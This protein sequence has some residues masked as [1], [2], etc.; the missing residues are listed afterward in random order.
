MSKLLDFE[1]LCILIF[2]VFPR[3]HEVFTC[4]HTVTGKGIYKKW[5]DE[6]RKS[7]YN[8]WTANLLYI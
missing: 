1:H 2:V 3:K 7:H 8:R 5:Q 6:V 4:H